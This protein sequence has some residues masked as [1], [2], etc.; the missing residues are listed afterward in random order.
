MDSSDSCAGRRVGREKTAGSETDA[1]SSIHIC[2]QPKKVGLRGRTS[3][4][5]RRSGP[6]WSFCV[7]R[8]HITSV[9][10]SLRGETELKHTP[11]VYALTLLHTHSSLFVTQPLHTGLSRLHPPVS[12]SAS[13]TGRGGCPRL[14]PRPHLSPPVFPHQTINRWLL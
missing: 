6:D 14:C 8:G 4:E 13:M 12:P 10:W 5:M 7:R 1:V 9:S 2:F 3:T 11:R